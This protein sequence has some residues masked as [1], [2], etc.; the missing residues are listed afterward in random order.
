MAELDTFI[1]RI[2]V[3]WTS[4]GQESYHVLAGSVHV[5]IT[6]VYVYKEIERM[7]LHMC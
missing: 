2:C 5:H 4:A 3:F 7:K 1:L 6:I